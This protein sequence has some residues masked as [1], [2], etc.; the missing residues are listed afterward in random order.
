M[1]FIFVTDVA[2]A[3]MLALQSDVTDEVFNVGTGVQTTLRQLCDALLRLQG[4]IMQPEYQPART[5]ANVRARKASISKAKKH[6]GFQAEVD[7]ETGLRELIEWR[8]ALRRQAVTVG[9]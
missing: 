5:V 2:R 7:L 8:A 1:D 4:S 9:S 6:L 3:N